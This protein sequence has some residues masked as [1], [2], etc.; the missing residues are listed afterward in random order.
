MLVL[1]NFRYE[2]QILRERL[3]SAIVA[4]FKNEI[5][6]EAVRWGLSTTIKHCEQYR[7]SRHDVYFTSGDGDTFISNT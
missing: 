2:N 5:E 6:S 7:T 4:T 1:S 3:T